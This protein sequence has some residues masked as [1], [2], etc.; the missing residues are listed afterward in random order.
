[1]SEA[2]LVGRDGRQYPLEQPRWRGDDGCP[3]LVRGGTGL[4]R[5]DIDV[6]GRSQWRYRSALPAI[7]EVVSLGEGR[8][9]LLELEID[10]RPFLAKAEWFNPT[11]SFKD[12]GTSAVVSLLRQQGIR[13]IV[14][15]SSGNGGSSL[16]AYAAAAGLEA[17]IVVPGGTSWTKTVEARTHGATVEVVEG[18]RD[19]AAAVA[20]S[21]AD[22]RFYAGHNWHPMFVEGMK[23]LAYELWED[24][25]FAA[26]DAIVVPVGAGSLVLGLVRGFEELVGA[27]E[28]E[29]VPRLLGVQPLNCSPL[30]RA[31]QAGEPDVTS[32][33][34][35]RTVAEGASIARPVRARE[36]LEAIRRSDGAL[37]SVSESEILESVRVAG[38]RGLFVE[39]TAAL[40]IAGLAHLSTSGR[41]GK[42]EVVV[43]VLT[44]FGAKASTA[45]LEQ[46]VRTLP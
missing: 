16:A 37:V 35:V 29:R 4:R 45:A 3:L 1:M 31:F 39:P 46:V 5:G 17:L 34:P 43:L 28:I 30:V 18:S 8:T 14:S 15:D 25:G 22:V 40:P 2:R 6:S 21:Y 20:A 23:L 44:G 33:S 32:G 7:N 12:R 42:H 26:P 27:G 19:H 24:L 36:V 9:P 38:A 11:A 10:G 41:I 13:R